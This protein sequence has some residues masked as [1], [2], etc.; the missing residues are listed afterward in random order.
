LHARGDIA[1]R[2]PEILGAHS[3]AMTSSHEPHLQAPLDQ[4]L[5]TTGPRTGLAAQLDSEWSRLR[6]S[7]RT[8]DSVRSWAPH[9]DEPTAEM[10]THVDDLDRVI[11]ATQARR[12]PPGE[13]LFRGLVG[14]AAQEQ[15]AGRIVVQRLLP[16]VLSATPR[17]RTLCEHDDP[18]GA[19]FG[20]LWLA[21]A[22]FDGE[23]RHG[24]AAA[25]IISDTMFIAFRRRT[26]LRSTDEAPIEPHTLDDEPATPTS[27]A[28]V[29]LADIIGAART[30][31]VPTYDIDL[32]R[33]LVRAESP[34][35]VARQ[36]KITP[37]TVRNHRDRAVER[38]RDAV[39]IPAA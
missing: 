4:P 38:I 13:R 27:C 24:P 29:E 3:G 32:I 14:L 21:I 26:R 10:I 34:G 8:L 5:P 37:R 36:R 30:A 18:I 23:R 33:H 16:G 20:A 39:G 1:V 11:E 28:F 2:S 17:Y 15:L 25:A 7:D 12:G 31:D 6:H 22:A 35:L 19:A 9:F